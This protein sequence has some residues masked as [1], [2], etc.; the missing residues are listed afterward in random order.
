M[1]DEKRKEE[2]KDADGGTKCQYK[3]NTVFL[4][5][6]TARDERTEGARKDLA[7]PP[8]GESTTR[9]R[10][11]YVVSTAAY[12]E[13]RLAARARDEKS[14]H[15]TRKLICRRSYTLFGRRQ[16]AK[17]LGTYNP[18]THIL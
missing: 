8:F 10:H 9:H 11:V 18:V 17:R 15:S 12:A 2:T 13:G 4:S 16:T 14:T 7:L 1:R 6:V 3:Y 5:M